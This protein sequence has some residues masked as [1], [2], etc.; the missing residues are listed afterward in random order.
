MSTLSLKQRILL[1]ASST[2]ALLAI[3]VG[4]SLWFMKANEARTFHFLDED[5]KLERQLTGA[6]AQGLQ[7]GQALRNILLDPSNPKAYTNYEKAEK[8]FNTA[9][10]AAVALGAKDMPNLPELKRLAG[11]WQPLR[12]QVIDTV[13][14]GDVMAARALL[15]AQ[16]TPAWRAT[17]AVLLDSLGKAETAAASAR[18]DL[19]AGGD[20]AILVTLILAVVT[21]MGCAA[22]SFWVMRSVMGLL[23]G[24]PAYASEVARRIAA[25]DLTAQIVTRDARADS[26]LATMAGMQRDLRTL[27]GQ[28]LQDTQAVRTAVSAVDKH[29]VEVTEASETQSEAGAAVAAAVEQLT[30]S[31]AHVADHADSADGQAESAASQAAEALQIIDR[32]AGTIADIST[33]LEASSTTMGRLE[34]S[35]DGISNIAQVIQEIAEQT[36]LLALNAA[37]EAARAGEQGRGFA[38][39][40]DEVRKLAERTAQSTH[41]ISG[42]IG[43]VQDSARE[44][45]ARM[46][47][48]QSM[49]ADGVANADRARQA[50]QS[51]HASSEA[52]RDAVLSIGNSVRE[53]R[54]ASTEIAQ[55]V[56]KIAQMTEKTFGSA[57]NSRDQVTQ[58]SALATSLGE[59]VGHFR[60]P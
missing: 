45:I 27:I 22:A 7:M 41:E 10:D 1:L 13:R 57:C 42:M 52:E 37:I 5:L 29:T 12:H 34:E 26:L 30:V 53:Q 55:R 48:G 40:A 23:G 39:V 15:N 16:E 18:A 33:R 32:A 51:L 4:C 54:A 28:I 60:L 11:E 6:Y 14:G 19:E 8:T 21:L 47:E 43:G 35:A 25:G 20:R 58:L 59:R 9:V 38:V 49:A 46:R 3:A 24:E 31:I 56:E 17:K 2:I 44:A 36:N 50:M